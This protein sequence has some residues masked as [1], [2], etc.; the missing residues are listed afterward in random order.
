MFGEKFLNNFKMVNSK[1]GQEPEVIHKK[2]SLEN[3]YSLTEFQSLKNERLRDEHLMHFDGYIKEANDPKNSNA[4]YL[5]FVEKDS[6]NYSVNLSP[7]QKRTYTCLNTV[8]DE[9]GSPFSK[10]SFFIKD[11]ILNKKMTLKIGHDLPLQAKKEI[12]DIIYRKLDD[13]KFTSN[14]AKWSEEAKADKEAECRE[15]LLGTVTKIVRKNIEISDDG[16]VNVEI[17]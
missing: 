3:P 10:L 9:K 2:G 7:S 13:K 4:R 1:K 6:N 14:Y 17:L 5:N 15:E 11:G 16:L 12:V 8:R